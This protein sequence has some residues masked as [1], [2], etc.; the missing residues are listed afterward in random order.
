MSMALEDIRVLDLTHYQA[1][2]TCTMLLAD[3]G[4]EV[5]KVE[6]PWGDQGR[7]LPPRDRGGLSP[8]FAHLNRNKKS[9]ALNLKHPRGV[10]IFKGL[11]RVSD[12]VVENFTPGTMERLG[13]GYKTLSESN[14]RIIFASISGFGQY[15][16]YSSRLS[17]DWIAQA[18]SGF[19]ALEGDAASPGGPPLVLVESL[20]DT[21]PGMFCT[22]GVLTALYRRALTGR[23]QRIDVAQLDSLISV[24][25]SVTYYTMSGLAWHQVAR[26]YRDF[27][28]SGIYRAKDGYVYVVAPPGGILDRL[29]EALHEEDVDQDAVRRWVQDRTTGEVVRTLVEAKVP[30]APILTIDKVIT[31]PQVLAREMIVGVEHPKAGLVKMPGFP[32]KFSETPGTIGKAAPLLGQHTEEVLT[33]LLGSS[34]DEIAKLREERV[35][36]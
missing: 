6:P 35:I 12:V 36:A 21:I 20:G 9:I 1:G 22:I 30:V 33:R 26:K 25:L 4:A 16:P 28:P 11:V 14:P 19:M 10:E 5:I 32:I 17:F 8:Y 3:M 13:L 18:M 31:D 2:P 15:G 27:G 7:L 23:G 34:G 29:T 24:I